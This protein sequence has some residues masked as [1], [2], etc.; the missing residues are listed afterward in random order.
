MDGERVA[1]P[2]GQYGYRII[3]MAS[4]LRLSR[5]WEPPVNDD[6]LTEMYEGWYLQAEGL[7]ASQNLYWQGWV[8]A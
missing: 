5:T 4:A 7:A 1:L 2:E 8:P 6:P 3:G